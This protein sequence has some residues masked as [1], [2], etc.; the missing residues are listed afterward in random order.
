VLVHFAGP[1]AREEQQTT[2]RVARAREKRAGLPGARSR[3]H[4][5]RAS[6]RKRA[7]ML[8]PPGDRIDSGWNCTPKRGSAVC[9][10]AIT[11]PSSVHAIVFNSGGSASAR[12]RSEWYRPAANGLA[13]PSEQRVAV[14][15]HE[16]AL[17]VRRRGIALQFAAVVLDERLVAETNAQDR[18][19]A[20]RDA[21]S[22]GMMPA[23]RG[24][25]G[26]GLR[27]SARGSR[28]SA[29]AAV[30]SSLHTTR[31]SGSMTAS[32]WYTFQ[33]NES[34]LSSRRITD[35]GGEFAAASDGGHQGGWRRLEGEIE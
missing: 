34:W 2:D 9:R 18:E 28:S 6:A 16:R 32:A 13:S 33:V 30:S 21:I 25:P 1:G 8:A 10:T 20:R 7:K 11:S 22:S 5:R 26:P 17:A 3:R 27:T 12:A 4:S 14:V 24:R 35:R 31:T 29:S 23:S 15:V 19:R